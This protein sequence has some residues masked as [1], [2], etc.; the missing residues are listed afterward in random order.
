MKIILDVFGGDYAPSEIVKGAIFALKELNNDVIIVLSGSEEEIRKELSQYEYDKT[1]IEIINAK[2]VITNDDI[3]TLAIKQK[4]ESSIVVALDY[5]KNNSDAIGLVSAGST[6]AVLTG[7]I[8]KIGRIKGIS[9]PGLAPILPTINNENVM[10]IDCGANMDSKPIYLA[11][12][13]LMGS[14]YMRSVYNIKN[15]RVALLSVGVEDKKGNEL[16]HE[17][18]KLLK[19]LPI[20]FVGNME[21]RDMLSGNYDVVVSDGFMG[22]VALKSLEGMAENL[23]KLIKQSITATF[24]RKIGA[25]ILKPALKEIAN[26]MDYKNSGGAVFLGIDKIIVKSHGSSKYKSVAASIKQVLSMHQSDLIS[27]IKDDLSKIDLNIDSAQ[28]N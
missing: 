27:N 16:T 21:A 6:G 13:A 11:H 10:L 28:N 18:F 22:N 19:Q 5:L 17:A 25:A 7:S 24:A 15:P 8:L 3:P 14:A 2:D 20:N 4:K 1:R 26:K 12:F 9:R 23:F